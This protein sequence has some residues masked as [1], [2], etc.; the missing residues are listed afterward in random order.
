MPEK[1]RGNNDNLT[2]DTKHQDDPVEDPV[3]DIDP[4]D[5]SPIRF[6]NLLDLQ[7]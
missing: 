5:H 4:L 7:R 1:A 6:P 3:G 2:Y